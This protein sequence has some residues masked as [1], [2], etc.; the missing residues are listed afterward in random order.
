MH[1]IALIRLS[2]VWFHKLFGT[3]STRKTGADLL[4]ERKYT[5]DQNKCDDNPPEYGFGYALEI[6]ATHPD[7]AYIDRC[8]K[9]A[10]PERICTV[11][12]IDAERG[13][14]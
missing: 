2:G 4:E 3:K 12:I 5:H 7:A 8:Q 10:E 9:Q 1:G 14:A 6:S 13:E 11:E